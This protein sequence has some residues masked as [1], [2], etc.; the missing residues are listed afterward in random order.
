MAHHGATSDDVAWGVMG[1]YDG[2]GWDGPRCVTSWGGH[3][4]MYVLA[5]PA[6]WE[7]HIPSIE[8]MGM[9]VTIHPIDLLGK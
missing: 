3:P 7:G 6:P 2:M 9:M 5:A 1:M 4:I 8:S